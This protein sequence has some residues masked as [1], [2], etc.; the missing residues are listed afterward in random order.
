MV[1]ADFKVL[2]HKW[3]L[4]RLIFRNPSKV[5][6]RI[7]EYAHKIADT[8]YAHAKLE[9][10]KP[11]DDVELPVQLQEIDVIAVLFHHSLLLGFLNIF[12]EWLVKTLPDWI[13]DPTSVKQVKSFLHP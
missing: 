7:P 8:Q 9:H 6:Y 10:P 12:L 5:A 11:I 13:F 2:G 4:I 1:S 3:S